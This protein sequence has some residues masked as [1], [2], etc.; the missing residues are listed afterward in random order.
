MCKGLPIRGIFLQN[1]AFDVML[2]MNLL[3]YI[4][5]SLRFLGL[6]TRLSLSP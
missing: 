1:L 2:A 4:S 3:N 6:K 5:D